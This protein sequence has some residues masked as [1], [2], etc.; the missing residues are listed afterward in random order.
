MA[1]ARR[2][3]QN[4]YPRSLDAY[5]NLP[6][7]SRFKSHPISPSG[8]ETKFTEAVNLPFCLYGL[9]R[10][11]PKTARTE[12]ITSSLPKR[13]PNIQF[14]RC[15]SYLISMSIA[16]Q[17][18]RRSLRFAGEIIYRQA[19]WMAVYR[20]WTPHGTPL[21]RLLQSNQVSCL[22]LPIWPPKRRW[23]CSSWTWNASLFCP[24]V[25]RSRSLIRILSGPQPTKAWM[26]LVHSVSLR[27]QTK[28][29]AGTQNNVISTY[30]HQ[31]SHFQLVLPTSNRRPVSSAFY[32][33]GEAI[34]VDK[35]M[36][37]SFLACPSSP[38]LKSSRP[39]SIPSL[40]YFSTK[41]ALCLP[42]LAMRDD[43]DACP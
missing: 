30:G 42:V 10:P 34:L 16:S 9:K 28:L 19:M 25:S 41:P 39:L 36:N 1:S 6:F 11:Q 22:H 27:Q 17:T 24:L 21:A 20:S 5:W 35:D 29:F 14:A 32:L 15:P 31:F 43:E 8:N 2:L 18:L 23:P 7:Y 40:L 37:P 26:P 3:L 4:M 12:N 38:Q 33:L 13:W